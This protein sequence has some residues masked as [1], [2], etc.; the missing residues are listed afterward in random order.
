MWSL[1]RSLMSARLGR[2]PRCWS[3]ERDAYSRT[4]FGATI[5]ASL[6]QHSFDHSHHST[7]KLLPYLSTPTSPPPPRPTLTPLLSRTTSEA[8]HHT[9]LCLQPLLDPCTP[10][11]G[12]H[13][14]DALVTHDT[15]I[16]ARKTHPRIHIPRLIHTHAAPAHSYDAHMHPSTGQYYNREGCNLFGHVRCRA[17]SPLVSAAPRS[18]VQ[19]RDPASL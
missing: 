17:H 1:E 13:T 14:T 10:R 16:S 18:L 8:R 7:S 2:P 9:A 19:S 5:V 11:H 3:V 12:A 4:G 6:S 15:T